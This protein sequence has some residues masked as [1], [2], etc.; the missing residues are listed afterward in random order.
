[1]INNNDSNRI[2]ERVAALTE[3]REKAAAFVPVEQVTVTL[4]VAARVADAAAF[5]AAVDLATELARFGDAAKRA[6]S[7]T[8]TEYNG[9]LAKKPTRDECAAALVSVFDMLAENGAMLVRGCDASQRKNKTTGEYE[10]HRP[11]KAP[12]GSQLE[13]YTIGADCPEF[14]VA[15]A[16]TA[17]AD[18]LRR[19]ACRVLDTREETLADDIK[20]LQ[21][22]AQ[23]HGVKFSM[24]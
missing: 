20:Y 12:S 8:D 7:N 5:F 10:Y 11:Y 14:A 16:E 24:Q 1:M 9:V 18:E 4:T 17:L 6:V 23:E 15:G 2:A 21:G 3:A 19:V 13:N 22:V